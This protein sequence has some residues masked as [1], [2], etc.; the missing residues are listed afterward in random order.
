MSCHKK[1]IKFYKNVLI[2]KYIDFIHKLPSKRKTILRRL[3]YMEIY[4]SSSLSK[5]SNELKK[6]GYNI[7]SDKN[8]VCDAIICN[9]K[10]GELNNLNIISNIK[11]GETI[12]IDYGRK[13]IN[14]IEYILNNRIYNNV[15]R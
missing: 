14:D 11:I 10:D 2:K 12:I 5:L 15:I 1:R 4:V 7:I 13:K 6:R 9:L 8:R 3:L